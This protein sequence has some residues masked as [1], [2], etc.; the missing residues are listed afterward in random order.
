MCKTVSTQFIPTEARTPDIYG[1]ANVPE[2]EE[3]EAL[4]DKLELD[5]KRAR[6]KESKAVQ[7]PKTRTPIKG[8]RLL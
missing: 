2:S 5:D 7:Q 6:A 8:K 4:L 1:Y 3:T